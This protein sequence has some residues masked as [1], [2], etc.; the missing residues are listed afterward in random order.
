MFDAD[1]QLNPVVIVTPLQKEPLPANAV[2]LGRRIRVARPTRTLGSMT[3]I[4]RPIAPARDTFLA[5]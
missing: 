5:V 1:Q 2:C 4:S 3:Y